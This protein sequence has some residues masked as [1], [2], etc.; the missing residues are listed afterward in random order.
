MSKDNFWEV[1]KLYKLLAP[2]CFESKPWESDPSDDHTVR[3][4]TGE[5]ILLIEYK[6]EKL[7]N[8]YNEEKLVISF[9]F[10]W[11]KRKIYKFHIV[12][13]HHNTDLMDLRLRALH[14]QKV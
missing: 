7:T 4:F 13:N 3:L 9:T 1:G 8:A 12:T 11:G 5:Y 10:L 14:F 2:V 6:E